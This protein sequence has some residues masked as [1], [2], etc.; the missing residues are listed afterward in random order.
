MTSIPQ[1]Q[2]V[3]FVITA[4]IPNG[5]LIAVYNS[6]STKVTDHNPGH[7]DEDRIRELQENYPKT[8]P[9]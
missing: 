6:T 2:G 3:D 7:A 5:K 1:T 9:T 4:P 8:V